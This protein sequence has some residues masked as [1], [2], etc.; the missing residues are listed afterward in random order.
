MVTARLWGKLLVVH[1]TFLTEGQ[2]SF[3]LLMAFVLFRM[4]AA[5]FCLLPTAVEIES[6]WKRKL[7]TGFQEAV[8]YKMMN[9]PASTDSNMVPKLR[10][11][12]G[13]SNKER[14]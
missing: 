14:L 12:E 3:G 6:A 4:P 7:L 9:T 10:E 1:E 2:I 13:H 8:H 5:V 11:N